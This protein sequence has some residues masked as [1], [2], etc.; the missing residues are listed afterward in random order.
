MAL[1]FL[2]YAVIAGYLLAI[3]LFGSW[4]ARFQKTTRDYFLT[5]RSVPGWAICC[6]I[7]ATETSTLTFIGVPAQAYAGNWTFLQLV[8]GYIIGRIIVSALFIPAYFRGELLT[9]YELLNRRFGP[10]VKNMSASIFL[11]TR[12]LAD[13]IR[14][15]A[16]AL[17]IT[18]V[19]GADMN[20]TIVILGAAM[21]VYTMRGGVSAVIWTDVVQ[22]FVYVAGAL[23]VFGSLLSQI[24][25]GWSAVVAAGSAANKFQVLNFSLQPSAVYTIFTGLL[26]GVAL[27]LSTHGTDQ[28]LVQ[29]LLSAKSLQAAQRGL[30]VSGFIV[31]IQFVLF[32]CIGLMLY[33]FYQQTPLPAPLGRND[34]ILPLFII[35]SLRNGAAGFI[36]AA[37]VAAALSPSINA[38]AATTVN[39]F[40]VKYIRPDADDATLLR[41]SKIATVFWGVVQIGV[42]LGAQTMERSVLDAGLAVLSLASGSV[43]G[44]FIIGTLLPRVGSAAMLSGMIAGLTAMFA[45]WLW[46]PIAWTWYSF[47]GAGMTVGV[48]W[49]LS[50]VLA[51]SH[52]I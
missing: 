42:A 39:D 27:T 16:T 29:R 35:H 23:L 12:S 5:D 14:L 38:M 43:L 40:Y 50:F 49:V 1:T 32:L 26:G 48:A 34:E 25:G 13:G 17:V 7:V 41:V 46:T 11:L 9:T 6:T 47:I 18:V 22:L 20:W 30:V 52:E 31:F 36:V 4:F 45:V 15:Y 21:I 3:T 51:P 8:V 33:T 10:S 24:D 44:A 28:Y 37:I 2:D 19:T